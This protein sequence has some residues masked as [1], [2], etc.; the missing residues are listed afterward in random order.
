MKGEVTA[1]DATFFGSIQMGAKLLSLDCHRAQKIAD[2]NLWQPRG[3]VL[4]ER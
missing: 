2:R 4:L 1:D 3:L